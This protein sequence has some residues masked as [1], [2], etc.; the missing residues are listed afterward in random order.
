MMLREIFC[1]INDP[2]EKSLSVTVLREALLAPAALYRIGSGVRNY[3]FDT[4]VLRQHRLPVPVISVGGLTVGGSGKTPVIRYLAEHLVDLGYRPA[5]LS[6][7]YGR[8]ERRPLLVTPN[9]TWGEVGDEPLLLATA[10]PGVP[11]M[12][13]PDRLLTGFLA[14]QNSGADILLMDDGFQHRRI[15]R[16]IDIVVIDAAHPLGNGRLLPAGPLRE[17]VRALSRAHAVFLTRVDQTESTENVRKLVQ[18][19][20]SGLP[21]IETA[22]RPTRLVRL[23]DAEPIPF[24]TLNGQRVVTLSGV[25]NPR[26]FEQTLETL[27]ATVVRSA[28][29]PDHHPFTPVDLEQVCR[30]AQEHKA[31]WIVT[32]EKDAMRLPTVRLPTHLTRLDI[33]LVLRSGETELK[34]LLLTCGLSGTR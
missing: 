4:G 2:D 27:G 30:L 9:Q 13:G 12:V 15:A 21:I 11:V 14:T 28:R 18:Q 7:G 5:I 1:R 33:A 24:A 32:T 26:S 20:S 16:T 19:H 22:Y 17:S 3:A 29:H 6:R 10:L 8:K 23:V 31:A 34:N 25:A